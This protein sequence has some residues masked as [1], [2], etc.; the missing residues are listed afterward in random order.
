[1]ILCIDCNSEKTNK[2]FYGFIEEHYTFFELFGWKFRKNKPP[3][4]PSYDDEDVSW[5]RVQW[6]E[7]Q[8]YGAKW[9][10]ETYNL[11]PI[12]KIESH[13]IEKKN[14][15]SRFFTL[16]FDQPN[17]IDGYKIQYKSGTRWRTIEEHKIEIWVDLRNENQG[18]VELKL[19]NNTLDLDNFSVTESILFRII[20]D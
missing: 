7:Y 10:E 17:L 18:L 8:K 2:E 12:S 11:S 1:M 19:Q 13:N 14:K 6:Q 16:S 5:T 20:K 9:I 4:S 3:I 15:D